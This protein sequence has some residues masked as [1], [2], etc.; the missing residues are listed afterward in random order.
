MSIVT[1]CD[2]CKREPEPFESYDK[3]NNLNINQPYWLLVRAD[4]ERPGVTYTPELDMVFR[5][6]EI[7]NPSRDE[8]Y[9][10]VCAK[11]LKNMID[12]NMDTE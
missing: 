7:K 6:S 12:S 8:Q 3:D 1:N 2:Y 10:Y 5:L 11:C 9:E 4:D